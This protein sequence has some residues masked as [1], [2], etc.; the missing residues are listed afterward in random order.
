MREIQHIVEK[1]YNLI[2]PL[3]NV[4]YVTRPAVADQYPVSADII[5]NDDEVARC[6]CIIQIDTSFL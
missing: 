1:I 3:S 5:E 6:N 4:S 2:T